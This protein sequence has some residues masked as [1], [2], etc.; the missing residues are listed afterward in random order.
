MDVADIERWHDSYV[1]DF[2]AVVRG[3]I[4]DARHLLSYYAFPLLVRSD[5][6]C[7]GAGG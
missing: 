2:A 5:A 1:A 7:P 3:D 4:D 6:G